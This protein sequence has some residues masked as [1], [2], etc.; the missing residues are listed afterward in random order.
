MC[1]HGEL[2]KYL[3]KLNIIAHCS[4]Y[5]WKVIVKRARF[6]KL[7]VVFTF[8]WVYCEL[9]LQIANIS[10]VKVKDSLT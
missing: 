6:T 1:F 5:I 8:T 10:A 3:V 4:Y 9:Q 2:L 7:I